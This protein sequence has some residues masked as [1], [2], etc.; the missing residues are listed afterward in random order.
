MTSIR[1]ISENIYYLGVS[2]YKYT[3]FENHIP[4][5]T[6]MAYNTYLIADEKTALIDTVEASLCGQFLDNLSEV[7]KE[8]GKSLDYVVVTHMEP[9]HSASLFRVL[10]LYPNA[11]IV[12]SKKAQAMFYQFFGDV[13]VNELIIDEG[14]I[15]ELGKH[16]LEFFSAPMVHWPEVMMCYEKYTKTLF[17]AD[18]FGAF[19]GLHGNLFD[20]EVEFTDSIIEDYRRYYTNIVGKYGMQTNRAIDKALKYDIKTICPL[21]GYILQ[22]EIGRFIELYRKWANYEP[23]VNGVLVIYASMYDNTK[24]AAMELAKMLKDR[25]VKKVEVKDVSAQDATYLVSDTFKYSDIVLASVTHN[26]NIYILMESYI[27]AVVALAI[28]NKRFYFIE[29]GTWAPASAKLMREKLA[30]LKKCELSE[31]V[32]SIKSALNNESREKLVE[33]ADE[34]ANNINK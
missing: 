25:G 18:A 15:L 9:D 2:D 28:Q 3:K 32:V 14:S 4:I 31:T 17:S 23:E 6:G 19:G 26:N 10:E 11:T 24:N 20:S 33:L 29:N 30:A 1:K 13:K 22:K 12:F 7:L 34:I 8:S 5:P 16:S 21:H 27:S